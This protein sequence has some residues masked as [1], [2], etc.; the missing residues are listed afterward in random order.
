MANFI[1]NPAM[2]MFLKLLEYSAIIMI[3]KVSKCRKYI[4]CTI[5]VLSTSL[6][7]GDWVRHFLMSTAN[8]RFHHHPCNARFLNLIGIFC[9]LQQTLL[10]IAWLEGFV[11][12]EETFT[13]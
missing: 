13:N 2:S 10:A 6:I 3:I 5:W 8:D 9:H 11:S 1:T 12:A 4:Q 7:S